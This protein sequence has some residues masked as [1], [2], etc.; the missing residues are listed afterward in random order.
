[1]AVFSLFGWPEGSIWVLV[2]PVEASL[3]LESDLEQSF[4]PETSRGELSQRL[5]PE[6]L[7]CAEV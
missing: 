6:S 3:V 1:M 7:E 5:R 2:K 4:P